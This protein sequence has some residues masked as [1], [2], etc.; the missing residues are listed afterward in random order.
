M[1]EYL[2]CKVFASLYRDSVVL[3]QVSQQLEAL[4]GVR[5]AAAMM[6]TPQNKDLLRAAALLPAE[7]EQAGANDLLVCVQAESATALAAALQ[8][9]AQQLSAPPAASSSGEATAP[10]TL[11]GALRHLPDA[12]LACI[13]VP[14]AYAAYEARKALR[15]GL[16]VF[17]FSD[18][19]P[20]AAE[21]ALKDL[22]AQQGVL[23]MGPDC[24][25][26]LLNG[27]PLGFANQVPRGP[28]GLVSASGTGLQHV[29]CLLAQ[30]GIGVSQAIGV[31]GRDLHAQVG[32]RS[33]R[34]A[35]RVLAADP[36]THVVVLISKPPDAAVAR[37]LAHEAAQLGKPCVWAVLGAP[38][39]PQA[40]LYRVATLAGAAQAAAAL[41]RGEP[42][43]K[44]DLRVSLALPPELVAARACLHPSQRAI[45][46]LY[47]G[48]TLA[49]E[50]LWLLRRWLGRVGSNLDDRS[51]AAPAAEHLVLDLG[52]ETYT[53]GRPH[54]IIDP[55]PRQQLL[56]EL[57][58]QPEVAVVL[59]DVILGWGAHASPGE[60][61][62]EAWQE[63]Q[64]EARA[65]GRRLVGIATV[66]GTPGD[67]QDLAAQCRV[68]RAQGMAV[69]LN[70]VEAVRWAAAIVGAKEAGQT[71]APEP[72][73]G[74]PLPAGLPVATA[75]AR[76]AALLAAGPRVINLGLERFAA[77]LARFGVPVVHV[78]WR[79]P[80]GGDVRL[81]R[82]LE[83][84]Q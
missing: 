5:R 51:E 12:N 20:L 74:E 80:A 79:P 8:A 10:R 32:G 16:N 81:L 78:D 77:S 57:A 45:R 70:H 6:G 53:G 39:P 48:G 73:A 27:L 28:V 54:P 1:S 42:V 31:G 63:A 64:A 22:A 34:A 72:A 75:P 4:P 41:A 21:V 35:L 59:C 84:L 60:A 58:R 25:T 40:T 38:A 23:L 24:G 44:E 62:A 65:A 30:Q 47:T 13:S 76:F 66:C 29:L 46:G 18:H 36:Q 2:G 68:L 49:Y 71:P 83:R 43:T 56:R 82:V 19:V 15:H 55:R 14:G 50:A 7:G 52:A 3:M 9:A 33:M 67:P 69:T 26:A 37:E 11:E 61:L 17:L